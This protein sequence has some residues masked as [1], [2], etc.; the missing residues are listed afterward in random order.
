MLTKTEIQKIID[1]IVSGLF[2]INQL[3]KSL[4]LDIFEQLE[5]ALIRGMNIPKNRKTLSKQKLNSFLQIS[6]NLR[7]FSAAKTYQVVKNVG[8]LTDID[9]MKEKFNLYMKTWQGVEND[10]TIKQGQ[11]VN[12]WY[13]YDEQK[14]VLPYLK[15]VTAKD[16]RVRHSHVLL[17]GIIKK[18]DDPFWDNYLPL[19]GYRCR[20]T[21]EQLEKAVPTK[22]TPSEQ[23]L[24]KQE[25]TT[26]FRNN[27]AKTGFVFQETGKEKHPYFVIPDKN[28]KAVEKLI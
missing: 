5:K 11:T 18:V 14:D 27:P 2:N 25:I 16:E 28:K 4:Y 9:E 13:L 21:V 3:P 1:G 7:R 10:L 20:C 6:G 26:Q 17:D 24:F 15:Y 8:M 12:D 19:N 23:K 22:V